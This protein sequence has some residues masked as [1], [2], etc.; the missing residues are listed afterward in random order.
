MT[1]G[2]MRELLNLHVELLEKSVTFGESLQELRANTSIIG[3][4]SATLLFG[5]ERATAINQ[6]GW[7]VL[8]AHGL[9]YAVKTYTSKTRT[10]K[11]KSST[12]ELADRAIIYRL[13]VVDCKMQLILVGTPSV[14][15]IKL[16]PMRLDS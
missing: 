16:S 7:D 5:G 10:M 4:Y 11:F 9:R 8:G 15:E 1:N 6:R 12:L 2:E 3:E 13:S 14:G